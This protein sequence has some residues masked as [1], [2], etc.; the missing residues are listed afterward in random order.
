MKKKKRQIWD[1]DSNTVLIPQLKKKKN[2]NIFK[3]IAYKKTFGQNAEDVP[4]IT[5]PAQCQ[6]KCGCTFDEGGP[7]SSVQNNL[8]NRDVFCLVKKLVEFLF[9]LRKSINIVLITF[10]YH[11]KFGSFILHTHYT[12]G[13]KETLNRPSLGNLKLDHL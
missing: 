6:G 12:L 4:T 9:Q 3:P 2:R 13:K 11:S 8:S 5:H 10:S 7:T 1:Y